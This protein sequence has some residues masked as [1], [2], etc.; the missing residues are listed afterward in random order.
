MKTYLRLNCMSR[1]SFTDFYRC[2]TERTSRTLT[3]ATY[4]FECGSL[5]FRERLRPV[6]PVRVVQ[7]LSPL[8]IMLRHPASQK[9]FTLIEVL[10]A[11]TVLVVSFTAVIQAVTMGAEMI[12]T[13]RKQQIAQQI[14]EGEI[15]GLRLGNWSDITNLADGTTYTA[16]INSTGNSITDTIHFKLGNNPDLMLQAKSFSCQVVA[17]YLRPASATSS[18]VTFLSVTYQVS[19]TSTSNRTHARTNTAFFG[20]NGLHLSYQK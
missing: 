10:M 14:I 19:W 4:K 17:S 13:A 7:P 6:P 5:D 18:T 3:S 12:D 11:A 8:S 2:L 20:Q 16:T 1:V 9:A 15:N